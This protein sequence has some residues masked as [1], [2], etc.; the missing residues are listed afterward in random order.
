MPDIDEITK[1]YDALEKQSDLIQLQKSAVK[2]LKT[3]EGTQPPS[4]AYQLREH[5]V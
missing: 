2:T 4:S 1:K 3:Y 5:A